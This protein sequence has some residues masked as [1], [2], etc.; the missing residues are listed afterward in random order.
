MNTQRGITQ[1]D[2][3]EDIFHNPILM[4]L[5]LRWYK[6]ENKGKKLRYANIKAQKDK[7][8][9]KYHDFIREIFENKDTF[10]KFLIYVRESVII[11][12]TLRESI[13]KSSK[14]KK[15]QLA[16]REDIITALLS[17]YDI[18]HQLNEVSKLTIS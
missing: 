18:H 11:S 7:D 5:I 1:C 17:F 6:C 3:I 15:S 4:R 13:Y 14:S 12:A 16:A 8:I 2:T 10:E 9:K